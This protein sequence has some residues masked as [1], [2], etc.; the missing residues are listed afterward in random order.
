MYSTVFLCLFFVL[1]FFFFG[2]IANH[3]YSL[4]KTKSRQPG[5]SICWTSR[6]KNAVFGEIRIRYKFFQLQPK[7]E[8]S[9]SSLGDRREKSFINFPFKSGNVAP[10]NNLH[11][12]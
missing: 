3:R 5:H 1:L 12:R 2:F 10:T 7:K 4:Q 9:S 6:N 8:T 11:F